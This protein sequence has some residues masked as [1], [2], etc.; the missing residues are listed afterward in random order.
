M[1]KKLCE[2]NMFKV[3]NN[4][5]LLLLILTHSLWATDVA[6]VGASKTSDLKVGDIVLAPF[7]EYL[8]CIREK[9]PVGAGKWLIIQR[10]PHDAPLVEGKIIK[11]ITNTI[12]LSPE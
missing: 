11:I 9:F 10:R 2:K 8:F 6:P 1:L 7:N 4:L 3:K 5:I 12:L